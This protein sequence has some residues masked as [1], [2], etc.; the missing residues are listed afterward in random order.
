[1]LAALDHRR[2]RSLQL[3]TP[4]A[5]VSVVIYRFPAMIY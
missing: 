1:M 4:A 3:S 2:S 5:R